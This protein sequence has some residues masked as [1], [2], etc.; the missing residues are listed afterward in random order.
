MKSP[1]GKNSLIR[2]MPFEEQPEQIQMA[3]NAQYMSS[4]ANVQSEHTLE[5]K[6]TEI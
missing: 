3:D 5:R 6:K 4:T 2:Q 1:L